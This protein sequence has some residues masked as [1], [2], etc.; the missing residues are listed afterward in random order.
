MNT[1]NLY[2]HIH[3]LLYSFFG[4]CN[5]LLNVV[6]FAGNHIA[7]P[8]NVQFIIRLNR[9]PLFNIPASQK[10]SW[11]FHLFLS[12]CVDGHFQEPVVDCV[13][14]VSRLNYLFLPSYYRYSFLSTL[15][16][17]FK[18]RPL[19][20]LSIQLVDQAHAKRGYNGDSVRMLL[21][22]PGIQLQR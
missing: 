11:P 20:V 10:A 6:T 8:A 5:Q 1:C 12:I 14:P 16:K 4:L 9:N 2:L 22:H 13:L 21:F 3:E 18:R 15:G 17:R 19:F 7:T